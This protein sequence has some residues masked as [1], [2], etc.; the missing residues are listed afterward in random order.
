M[1]YPHSEVTNVYFEVDKGTTWSIFTDESLGLL[2]SE[3]W[4]V[5]LGHEFR[6]LS[7][8]CIVLLSPITREATQ[9]SSLPFCGIILEIRLQPQNSQPKYMPSLLC[10]KIKAVKLSQS[11]K[12]CM[13]PSW[14]VLQYVSLPTSRDD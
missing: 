12:S 6:G 3:S 5:Y 13:S 14:L 7:W 8:N 10:W 11:H 2:T 4:I 1:N 9:H